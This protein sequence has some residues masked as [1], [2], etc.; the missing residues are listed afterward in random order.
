M[1]PVVLIEI[2]DITVFNTVKWMDRYCNKIKNRCYSV[3][4]YDMYLCV[5]KYLCKL[6]MRWTRSNNYNSNEY[7]LCPGVFF[8]YF[9]LCQVLDSSLVI[10]VGSC[11]ILHRGTWTDSLAVAFRPSS[12]SPWAQLLHRN[13]C[14]V[15]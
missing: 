2:L 11:R 6:T 4:V 9:W 5:C 10:F 3:C 14:K 12:C 7:T 8:F 1:S 15:L 13:I